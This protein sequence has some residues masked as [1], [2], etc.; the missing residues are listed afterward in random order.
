[1][2]HKLVIAVIMFVIAMLIGHHNATAAVKINTPDPRLD[3][4]ATAIAGHPVTVYCE[5]DPAAWAAG[6]SP[7]AWGY[8]W[9]P[10]WNGILPPAL[11]NVVW[12]HPI[13]CATLHS[14]MDNHD[15]TQPYDAALAIHI[16]V[17]ESFHQRDGVYGDCTQTDKS[18][19]GRA[20]C[21]ALAYDET[22]ET[23]LFGFPATVTT[24]EV[25][26]NTVYR[27]VRRKVR[28]HW[29]RVRVKRQVST[30]VSTTS[31]NLILDYMHTIQQNY[32][33]DI[34]TRFPQYKGDC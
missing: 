1:M 18:C 25:V 11:Q 15:G 26:T 8:T 20:D 14:L 19:E 17:H 27:Y 29:R 32:H 7:G 34:S 13:V 21:G 22:A 16:L 10:H 33:N 12:V 2:V 9:P 24:T 30:V 5:N 31:R 28:G 6:G 4:I 3:Q 23:T